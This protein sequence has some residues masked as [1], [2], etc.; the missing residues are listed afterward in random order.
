MLKV[1][2]P[3]QSFP[4]SLVEAKHQLG[5]FHSEDDAHVQGLIAIATEE[6][7]RATGVYTHFI[8]VKQT[9]SCFPAGMITLL[10][11][12]F[13]KIESIQYYD[14]DNTLQTWAA[15]N[16]R[17]YSHN[18]D[19]EIE[20]I[21]GWPTIYD[22]QDAIQITYVLGSATVATPDADND[23]FT[24]SGH[25]FSDGDEV[26]VYTS[27]EGAVP[28]GLTA[29]KVYYVVGS[30]TDTIQLSATN[31]G[32]AIDI[33]DVGSGVVYIGFQEVSRR[34]K[35]AIKM[36]LAGLDNYRT[37]QIT[38]TMISDVVR[39]SEYLLNQIKPRLL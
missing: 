4:V 27:D 21:N 12:P 33:A 20:E 31:G 29:R 8:T 26:I 34:Q 39:S 1:T 22:R 28:T 25:P 24:I 10:K 23:N 2:I 15:S 5:Y 19:A 7:E 38:G 36:I 3:A 35:A 30:T 37:D 13:A 32:A 16:Y 11:Y 17:V 18:L 9:L 14:A 6:A